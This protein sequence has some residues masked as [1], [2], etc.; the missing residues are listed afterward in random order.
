M[1]Q[2]EKEN[3]RLQA[4][5]AELQSQINELSVARDALEAAKAEKASSQNETALLESQISELKGEVSRLSNELEKTSREN[6]SNLKGLSENS[7]QI[8]AL[9][10]TLAEKAQQ[11]A[12]LIR[13]LEGER[14]AKASL[15]A[16]VAQLRQECQRHVDDK[17][18]KLASFTE[19]MKN[20]NRELNDVLRDKARR[21]EEL[22]SQVRSASD[23]ESEL[24]KSR[25]KARELEDLVENTLKECTS[26]VA[27]L[28]IPVKAGCE[29]G[30]F[31]TQM[32]NAITAKWN[33]KEDELRTK[34]AEL[35]KLRSAQEQNASFNQTI[36]QLKEQLEK[37]ENS[38]KR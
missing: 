6:A 3:D 29:L 27:A 14:E 21:I 7:A 4:E 19:D 32:S 20:A 30:E 18:S 11:I 1:R 16:T 34:D 5:F 12:S 31:V 22:E 2:A 37:D 25:A 15:E 26:F 33:E 38:L 8:E 10:M 17:D 35:V 36:E 24:E 23:A 9:R 28:K 13:D